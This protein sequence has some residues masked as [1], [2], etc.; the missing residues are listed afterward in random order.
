MSQVVAADEPAVDVVLGR[1]RKAGAV[2]AQPA[3]RRCTVLDFPRNHH[4]VAWAAWRLGGDRDA[5]LRLIGEAVLTEEEPFYGPLV[6]LGDF[7]PAAATYADRVRHVMEHGDTWARLQA[8]VALWSITSEPEPSVSV[9]EEYLPP[10][11]HGDDT[12]GSFLDALQA[13]A[14]IGTISPA[15]RAVLRTVQGFDRRLAAHRDYR[16][17]LQDEEIRS[18]IDD[19][20]ALP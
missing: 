10:V 11:A 2:F 17:I 1:C 19:V 18:A 16:A 7:G 6:W 15:A 9:L 4:K 8:A 12:Y 13:L 3:V 5:A 14:R 20:L